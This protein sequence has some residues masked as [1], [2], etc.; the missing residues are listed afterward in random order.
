MA[1]ERR[2]T[3]EY[4]KTFRTLY[5]LAKL[6]IGFS[7]RL[8]VEGKE[9]VPTGPVV[10]AANH[11]SEFDPLFL[12]LAYYE[13]TQ[14]PIHFLAKKEYFEGGGIDDKGKFGRIVRMLVTKTGQIPVDR[15]SRRGNEESIAAAV[16]MLDQ[17]DAVGIFPEGTLVGPGRLG[18]LHR[19]VAE[20]ALKASGSGVPI[21]PVAIMEADHTSGRRKDVRVEFGEPI[22]TT[23]RSKGLGHLLPTRVKANL[24]TNDLEN[25]LAELTGLTKTGVFAKPGEYRYRRD[26]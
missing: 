23:E 26:G 9:H 4:A 14:Q 20:I 1:I 12:A 13:Q 6:A 18:R 24:I 21:I 25:T 2:T 7:Y 22:D 16:E 11:K 10:F 8:S 5:P 3:A 15:G 19:G 17:G